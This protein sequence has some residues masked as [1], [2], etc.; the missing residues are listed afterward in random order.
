MKIVSVW[1]RRGLSD[2]V[3]VLATIEDWIEY[4]RTPLCFPASGLDIQ[5]RRRGVPDT[6]VRPWR[7]SNPN[8]HLVCAIGDWYLGIGYIFGGQRTILLCRYVRFKCRIILEELVLSDGSRRW[9]IFGGDLDSF[10]CVC[11]TIMSASRDKTR[12]THFPY[13]EVSLFP[14][15]HEHFV[16]S[17]FSTRD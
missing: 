5:E 15:P 14:S 1:F 6:N 11:P 3:C 8:P 13:S 4:P 10:G 2:V 12:T 16:A 17:V 9:E 7:Y